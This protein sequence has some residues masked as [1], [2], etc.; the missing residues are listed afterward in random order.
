MASK[1]LQATYLP[2]MISGEWTGTMNLTEPDA[3]SDV[4]AVRTRAVRHDDGTYR[5]TG[6]K[7]FISFGEHDLADNIVHLVLARTPDAPPGTR[8]ISC[9]VVPKFLIEADGSLGARNDVTCVSIEHKTGITASPTC[10]LS[11]GEASG[12]VGYLL[13]EEQRGM[14]TMF[15]MMNQA[16]LSVGMQG[17][18]LAERAY[19]HAL[20]YAHERHQGRAPGAPAG[21]SSPII[22]HPDVR[23]M[24]M[25][26]KASIEA[27]RRL[28]YVNAEAIDRSLHSPDPDERAAA[29]ERAALLTPLSKGWCTDMGVELTGTRGADPRRDGLRGGD[30][31]R[32]TLAR[33][34]HHHHLRGDQRHPGHR[35]RRAQTG[36]AWRGSGRRAPRCHRRAR[37]RARYPPGPDRDP[38]AAGH[39]RRRGPPGERVA[40]RPRRRS[41]GGVGRRHAVPPAARH[42]H[43]RWADGALRADRTRNT[44]RPEPATPRSSKLAVATARFFCEQLLP[45]ADGLEA[46]VCA[47]SE[48][49]SFDPAV[50]AH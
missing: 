50:L 4:G 8:G 5:I 48:P 1:E 44:S 39:V 12:A 19:Q 34:S 22:D 23:R 45:Q 27:M 40:P 42:R 25:T 32:P 36:D 17:L 33:R 30:R 15:T 37:R 14:A 10:V 21:E 2:K 20:T 9:F 43:C 18:S 6:T 11:F 49:L 26:M 28:V 13:G 29:I 31:H 47:G 16:R 7:I 46:A 38:G 24:L 3:G 41:A 35:S